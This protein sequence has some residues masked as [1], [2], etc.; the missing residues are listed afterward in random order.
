MKT[1]TNT[2]K[3]PRTLARTWD[4]ET[5]QYSYFFLT[6]SGTRRY[7]VVETKYGTFD[8][9]CYYGYEVR[10]GKLEGKFSLRETEVSDSL[11]TQVL[12][13]GESV[14]LP[15]HSETYH[16]TAMRTGVFRP[17][18]NRAYARQS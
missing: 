3:Q 2:S 11:W 7:K 1:V 18:L 12:A 16:Q 13:A 5:G 8:A 15:T 10:T 14:T 6:A 4:D 9:G 17:S